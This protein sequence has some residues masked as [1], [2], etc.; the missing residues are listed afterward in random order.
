MDTRVSDTT[1]ELHVNPMNANTDQLAGQA[2]AT[3][4]PAKTSTIPSKVSSVDPPARRKTWFN[5]YDEEWA[6]FLAESSLKK[7]RPGINND[8]PE[9]LPRVWNSPL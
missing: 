1:H 4:S 8:A 7:T 9:T 3:D 6:A 5:S 2:P